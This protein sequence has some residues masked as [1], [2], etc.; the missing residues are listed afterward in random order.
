MINSRSDPR[1]IGS[2][3]MAWKWG[4]WGDEIAGESRREPIEGYC[5]LAGRE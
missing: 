5:G 4:K 1:V 3:C 2:K